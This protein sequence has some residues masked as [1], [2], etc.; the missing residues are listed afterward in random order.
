M[1]Q[2]VVTVCMAAWSAHCLD[3]RPVIQDMRLQ[4]CLARGQEIASD[5][6][7]DHPKWM[8]SGWRCEVGVPKQIES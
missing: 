4:A 5:W 3:E 7:S 6:L 8:L 2:L 1:A